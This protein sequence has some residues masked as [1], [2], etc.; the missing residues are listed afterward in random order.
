MKRHYAAPVHKAYAVAAIGLI[1]VLGCLVWLG[2][3]A[4]A[5]D[6][7]PIKPV[8]GPEHKTVEVKGVSKN[9]AQITICERGDCQSAVVYGGDVRLALSF[10]G[11]TAF[12]GT[13]P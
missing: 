12:E 3:T 5:T 6:S 11:V 13:A 1:A 7:F 2:S 9:K 8:N 10:A 4:G